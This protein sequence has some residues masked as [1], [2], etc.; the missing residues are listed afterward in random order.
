MYACDKSNT[1][2]ENHHKNTGDSL[3]FSYDRGVKQPG[4]ALYKLTCANDRIAS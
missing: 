1:V 2:L 4:R 3:D